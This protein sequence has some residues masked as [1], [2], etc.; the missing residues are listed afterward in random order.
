LSI[1]LEDGGTE[2]WVRDPDTGGWSKVV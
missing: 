1:G 2:E